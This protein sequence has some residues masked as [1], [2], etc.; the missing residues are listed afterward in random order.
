MQK[1]DNRQETN[2]EIGNVSVGVVGGGLRG[3]REKILFPTRQEGKVMKLTRGFF[4]TAW[5]GDSWSPSS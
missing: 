2:R 5:R 3:E 1:T 4:L